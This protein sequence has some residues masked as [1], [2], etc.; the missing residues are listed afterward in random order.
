MSHKLVNIPKFHKRWSNWVFECGLR[1]N[2]S[3]ADW[4][5][6]HIY[7]GSGVKNT[8]FKFLSI[9]GYVAFKLRNFVENYIYVHANFY[10]IIEVNIVHVSLHKEL[11][12]GS[13]WVQRLKHVHELPL[14]R[15][16]KEKQLLFRLTK[17]HIK[18]Y[19]HLNYVK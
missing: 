13:E 11:D 3:K 18:R 8:F 4:V 12:I 6:I 10:K 19:K 17:Y 2:Y 15:N 5:D 9:E 16:S 1:Q 14:V 7:I